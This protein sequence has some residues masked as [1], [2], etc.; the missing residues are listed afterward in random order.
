[1]YT[2]LKEGRLPI[3][4]IMT[5]DAKINTSLPEIFTDHFTP[6][7]FWLDST[8]LAKLFHSA[9]SLLDLSEHF[10]NKYVTENDHMSHLCFLN[11]FTS[12]RKHGASV[13]FQDCMH[14]V[15]LWTSNHKQWLCPLRGSQDED[16]NVLTHARFSCSWNFKCQVFSPVC[17]NS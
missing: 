1:M 16:A 11:L 7:P 15:K 8:D 10:V 4:V 17:Q 14:N 6:F 9:R 5:E 13:N 3:K 2:C 12:R